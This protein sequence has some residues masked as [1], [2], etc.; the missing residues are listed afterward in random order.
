MPKRILNPTK[1]IDISGPLRLS[2]AR[3][4]KSGMKIYGVTDQLQSGRTVPQ[5]Q[6]DHFFL[7]FP[8]VK[9]VEKILVVTS[10]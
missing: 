7:A 6:K 9:E 10:S 8:I 3:S 5:W 1:T 2:E 4:T